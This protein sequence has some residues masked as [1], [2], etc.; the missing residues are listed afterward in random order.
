MSLKEMAETAVEDL[1][2]HLER[3]MDLS[4]MEQG[5]KLVGTVLAQKTLNK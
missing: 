3:N 4:T 1:V 5:I 2:V